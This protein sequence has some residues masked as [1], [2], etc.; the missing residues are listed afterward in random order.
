MSLDRLENIVVAKFIVFNPELP[1]LFDK[2]FDDRKP[3]SGKFLV[4]GAMYFIM[5]PLFKWYISADEENK[6]ANS[7]VLFLNYSK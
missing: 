2:R 4:L 5:S 1:V 3:V 6:P 7:V